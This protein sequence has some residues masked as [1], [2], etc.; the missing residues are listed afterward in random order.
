[1]LHSK[2]LFM[3]VYKLFSGS[4]GRSARIGRIFDLC[5][6]VLHKYGNERPKK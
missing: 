2:I 5:D 4:G 6:W 1:M 3:V